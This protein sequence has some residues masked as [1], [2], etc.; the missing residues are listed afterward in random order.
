MKEHP[1][2]CFLNPGSVAVV[3]ASRKTG[4]GSFNL[5]E[6]MIKFGFKG[7]I[8]PINPSAREIMG[9]KACRQIDDIK[10]RVD[11][12]VILI[13]RGQVPGA[14]ESCARRGIRGAVIVPQGFADADETGKHLQKQL[15]LISRNTGIRLVGPN[16]LGV[17][18]AYSGFSTS[19][20]PHKRQKVPVGVI[21]QSG[22]FFVG[23]AVFTGMLGKGIDIGNGC[24]L[25]FA[26][27]LE[28]FGNDHDIDVIFIH[29]EGMIRGR[30]FYEIAGRVARRKPII[31]LKA[32]R[33]E[34]GAQAAMSHSGALVGRHEVFEAAFQQAGITTALD[35]QD[36][37][38]FT[39][40]L[41][42]LGSMEGNRIGVVTLTGA[43]G[44]LLIDALKQNGLQLAELSPHTI[45]RVQALSP[46][47]MSIRN[48]LDIWP[49]LMKHGMDEVYRVALEGLL[50]DPGVDGVICLAIAPE[51]PAQAD[52]DATP[53]IGETAANHGRKP[54]VTWLYGP[55]QNIVSE[56]LEASS[57]VLSFPSLDRAARALSVL[58][59]RGRFLKTI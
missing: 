8:Y 6:Q 28:Y 2:E 9:L 44:I 45:E 3:G 41:L 1:L 5:I 30:R 11:L 51:L 50:Q 15:T 10:D 24:D 40:A 17:I 59:K 37:Q 7:K 53:V 19:F 4:K 36:V 35:S 34:E 21:C 26:D 12:A 47:W 55:N 22:I 56:T 25:D 32:A 23:S 14:V 43:G 20:V 52:L 38:D 48:P 39:R 54:V 33:S 18:N 57:P 31:A 16:T 27:A 42:H 29:I 13:P 46:V 58:Y 49:A